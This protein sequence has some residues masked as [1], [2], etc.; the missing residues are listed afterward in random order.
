MI[1]Q[2][3]KKPIPGEGGVFRASYEEVNNNEF[4]R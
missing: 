3:V 2:Y 1:K 4:G